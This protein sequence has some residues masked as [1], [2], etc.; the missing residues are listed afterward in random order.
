MSSTINGSINNL[1]NWAEEPKLKLVTNL[2]TNYQLFHITELNIL[3]EVTDIESYI[4]VRFQKLLSSC[5]FANISVVKI[6]SYEKGKTNIYFGFKQENYNGESDSEKDLYNTILQH[7]LSFKVDDTLKNKVFLDL[8][9]D[10]KFGGIICGNLVSIEENH[11]NIAPILKSLSLNNKKTLIAIFSKPVEKNVLEKHKNLLMD[12]YKDTKPKEFI[13]SFMGDRASEYLSTRNLWAPVRQSLI[14]RLHL[15]INIGFWETELSFVTQD[16]ISADTLKGI[17]I[18]ELANHSRLQQEPISIIQGKEQNFGMYLSEKGT[19][20]IFLKKMHM[21]LTSSELSVISSV[22]RVS[23]PGFEIRK[24]PSLGLTDVSFGFRKNTVGNIM[25]NGVESETNTFSLSNETLNKHVFIT[26][27]TG[28]GK[29]TTVKQILKSTFQ[30]FQIPFLVIESAKRDY[31]Q[32]L[33]DPILQNDLRIFTIGDSQTNPIKINPFYVQKGVKLSSH[34]D[35]LKAIFNASFSLYG[36]MPSILEKCLNTVYESLGWDLI[37]GLHYSSWNSE[38]EFKA[39]KFYENPG[40]HYF[41]PTLKSLKNE[42]ERYINQVGYQGELKENIKTAILVRLEMLTTGANGLMF[43][44]YDFHPI[45]DLLSHPTIFEMEDLVDDDDK[46]FFVALLITL[47]NEYRQ[48]E[49]PSINP[50]STS[51]GLQ[52]LLVIE[53]AHRLLKNISSEKSSDQLGNPKGKAVELFGHVLAEMRSM[54]QGVIIAEQIPSKLAPDVIKNSNTKIVHRLVARDDQTLLAGSLNIGD[55][56]ALYL[57]QLVTGHA[58]CHKEGMELPVEVVFPNN[59]EKNGI[60]NDKVKEIMKTHLCSSLHSSRAFQLQKILKE[61]GKQM[62]TKFLN[63]LGVS[64]E[65]H[66]SELPDT[67]LTELKNIIWKNKI[68][69]FFYDEDLVDYAILQI[70]ELFRDGVYNNKG[71]LPNN[72]NEHF[73]NLFQ[74]KDKN[75]YDSLIAI[76]DNYFEEQFAVKCLYLVQNMVNTHFE[77]SSDK[78]S[79]QEDIIYVVNDCLL[80]KDI[81]TINSILTN[82][83]NILW[84]PSTQMTHLNKRQPI[85]KEST[86]NKQKSSSQKIKRWLNMN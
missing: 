42:I 11:F 13:K 29:S 45:K 31:R 35:F 51:K 84:N 75:S 3:N 73:R 9:G 85:M 71:L 36:P 30:N 70:V 38:N 64:G 7:Y 47:I 8:T 1:F 50:N 52:H 15:G 44:T 2:L 22:P 16:K 39:D 56:D 27:I 68:S 55:H 79:T 49:N 76:L 18:G 69:N 57:N 17:F 41:F 43:N 19:K 33:S 5:Y 63:S 24:A 77:S 28:S 78:I 37:T 58:L 46:A 25:E 62:L 4:N 20:D 53:E 21:Y 34:I 54:G 48:K 60:D 32:L 26:G 72:I 14:D 6:F 74:S 82:T 10:T 12:D 23:I 67:L 59:V 65:D 66:F 86:S 83:K 80:I 61:E 40:H 81:R